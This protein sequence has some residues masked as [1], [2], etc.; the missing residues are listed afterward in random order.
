M[1]KTSTEIKNAFLDGI[2]LVYSTLFTNNLLFYLLEETQDKN[3]YGEVKQRKYKPP[4]TISGSVEDIVEDEGNEVEV[5]QRSVKI[6]IPTK[7][8]E[9]NK[10]N[11]TTLVDLKNLEGAKFSYEGI[12]YEVDSV[13]PTT[14]ICEE[15]QIYEFSCS[16]IKESSGD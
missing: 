9:D 8:L 1:A 7:E 11:H 2:Q 14:M 13:K 4:I 12:E 15:W 6:T 10:I 5:N 3:I 16:L